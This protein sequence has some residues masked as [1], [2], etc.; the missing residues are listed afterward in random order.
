MLFDIVALPNPRLSPLIHPS[1][2]STALHGDL[3]AL[4]VA[5]VPVV[6]QGV[7][8]LW[9]A[10]GEVVPNARGGG[11]EGGDLEGDA[12]GVHVALGCAGGG[13]VEVVSAALAAV[14]EAELIATLEGDGDVTAVLID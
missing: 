12:T 11:V 3:L 8:G 10:A 1:F 5:V 13:L 9:V 4:V 14:Q 6:G 7:D 2:H